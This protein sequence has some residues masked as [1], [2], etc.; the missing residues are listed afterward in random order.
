MNRTELLKT[1]IVPS[2]FPILSLVDGVVIRFA[3]LFPRKGLANDIIFVRTDN[4]GDFVLW[5]A[6]ASALR[7]QWP[8]PGRRF[9]LIANASWA[10]LA[11]SLQLFDEV[12]PIERTKFQ[13]HPAYR[14][15]SLSRLARRQAE[16]LVNP[17]HGRDPL[18]SDTIS[19][20]IDADRKVVARGDTS[21]ALGQEVR[22]NRWYDELIDSADVSVHQAI[23][24]SEFLARFC[25]IELADPWPN[26]RSPESRHSSADLP[27]ARYVVIAPGAAASR[28]AWP[29]E[30]FAHLAERFAREVS[31]QVVLVGSPSEVS[32]VNKLARLCSIPLFNLAGKLTLH[33]ILPVLQKAELILTNETGT[34]HLGAAFRVPTVCITGGGHFKRFVPYPKEAERAGIRLFPI[35]HDMPCFG[36]N[37]QCIYHMRH[38]DAAPCIVNVDADA[39]WEAT[40]LVLDFR[41]VNYKE[42]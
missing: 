17:I 33:D 2:L 20:A 25:G 27:S 42:S 1:Y 29:P 13:R 35:Y 3:R 32:F 11:R 28:R 7:K 26:M 41:A 31:L 23:R 38:G 18:S 5:L 9:V 22:A 40:K 6:A 24:N 15:A 8:W 39:V 34:A 37:W 30:R 10:E 4:L 16:L 36:C 12:I 14:F 19:R 21:N